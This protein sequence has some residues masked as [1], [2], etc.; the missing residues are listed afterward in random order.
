MQPLVREMKST[1]G[2][3]LS[4]QPAGAYDAKKCQDLASLAQCPPNAC[5]WP[6]GPSSVPRSCSSCLSSAADSAKKEDAHVF[7]QAQ[8]ETILCS[9]YLTVCEQYNPYGVRCVNPLASHCEVVKN[10]NKKGLHQKA[11][12]IADR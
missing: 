3:I 6:R 4:V 5:H 7:G 9:M 11:W 2:Y 12:L 10:K 1:S 8:H